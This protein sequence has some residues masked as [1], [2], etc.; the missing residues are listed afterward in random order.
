MG[1]P[2]QATKALFASVLG[3]AS[4]VAVSAGPIDECARIFE[5]EIADGVIHGAAVVSGSLDGDDVSAS[6][7]WADAAHKVPMTPDT[8]IDMASVTKA[9]AG[10]TAYLV[11]HAKGLV[12]LDAPFTNDL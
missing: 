1:Q 3:L 7:G 5:A 2:N 6:W 8:V 10:V 4:A 9:S 12:D 11:A